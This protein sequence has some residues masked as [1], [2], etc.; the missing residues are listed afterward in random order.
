LN[1]RPLTPHVN[2][3]DPHPQYFNETRGDVR[4]V[5]V[6]LANTANGWLQLDASGK[7][8][9]AQLSAIASRHVVAADQ[10]AR[11]ALASS[12][13][14]TICAQADIDTLFYLNGGAN[15]A[16]AANWVLGQSAT[17]SGVSSVFGR[18]G[19][20]MFRAHL[21]QATGMFKY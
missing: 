3:T 15:P 21:Q 8:P 6:S 10:T 19:A 18:T 13:N 9:A 7:I 2:D 5:Q 12:A 14:L 17:V 11:L 16:V 20:V 1:L 4:Y